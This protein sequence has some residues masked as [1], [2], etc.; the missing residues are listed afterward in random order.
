M[1]LD[2]R[3]CVTL[4]EDDAH[5]CASSARIVAVRRDLI[6][7]ALVLDM[8]ARLSDEIETEMRRLWLVF[9]AV[10]DVSMPLD[11][12]NVP[13]GIW[14][15]GPLW[16]VSGAE[17]GLR[18]FTIPVIMGSRSAPEGSP[19]CDLRVTAKSAFAVASVA[20]AKEGLHTRFRTR[21]SVADDMSM[22]AAAEQ[23]P[24]L[25]TSG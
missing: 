19:K 15:A 20:T 12:A 5:E 7:W 4:G 6:P 18:E 9:P 22:L 1:E 8:D 25:T 11:R 14:T 2:H 23:S 16:S 3:R 24:C 17:D 10:D 21:S 13:T